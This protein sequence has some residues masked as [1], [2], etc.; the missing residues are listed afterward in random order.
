M[1]MHIKQPTRIKSAGNMVKIID[2]YIG[3]VN[4]KSSSLSI[5]KMQSP[6]G[7]EEPAQTPDFDEYTIVLKGVVRVKTDN[8][9]FIIRAGEAFIAKKGERIQ[10]STPDPDGAEYIAVCLPAFSQETVHREE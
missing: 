8:D 10:Y 6:A 4:S 9:H 3:R 1:A 7:W 2:E 5:A